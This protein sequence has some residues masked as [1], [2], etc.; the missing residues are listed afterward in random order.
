[1]N[2]GSPYRSC[3]PENCN[4]FSGAGA[5]N[6]FLSGLA[7]VINRSMEMF[8]SLLGTWIPITLSFLATYLTGRVVLMS[9][10]T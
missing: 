6:G 9:K 10:G 1:M 8:Q 4:D 5:G 7:L 2:R 3:L